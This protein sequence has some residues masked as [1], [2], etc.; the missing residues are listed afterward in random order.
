MTL[1]INSY[2]YQAYNFLTYEATPKMMVIIKVH[3][4]A[5]MIIVYI[6]KTSLEGFSSRNGCSNG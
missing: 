6:S 3:F 1:D 2:T 4:L 5:I